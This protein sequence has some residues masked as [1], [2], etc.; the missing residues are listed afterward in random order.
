MS[1]EQTIEKDKEETPLENK[2]SEKKDKVN[3]NPDFRREQELPLQE[4]GLAKILMNKPAPHVSAQAWAI[5]D[6]ESE[7]LLFGRLEKDR[8]EIASLTKIMT[9]YTIFSLAK[10]FNVEI[11]KEV[12]EID[13]EVARVGG[14]SADLVAGDKLTI[15]QLLYGLMLPSGNDAAVCLAQFF[16]NLI[17]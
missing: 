6:R 3:L 8:R 16:G 4:I 1:G 2:K 14:T 11:E 17:C 5:Y 7:K 12:I 13:A 15:L 9:A 10:R